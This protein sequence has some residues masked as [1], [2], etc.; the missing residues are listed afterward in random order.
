MMESNTKRALATAFLLVVCGIGIGVWLPK[1]LGIEGTTG[2][3]STPDVPPIVLSP[4]EQHVIATLNSAFSKPPPVDQLLPVAKSIAGGET[5]L[6]VPKMD[7]V[8]EMFYIC[9]TV[10]S[11]ADRCS[12]QFYINNTSHLGTILRSGTTLSLTF[13]SETGEIY[14]NDRIG[15]SI[16]PKE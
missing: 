1:L 4:M 10:V 12:S 14:V 8:V 2:Q 9:G 15:Y 5:A 11:S 13:N 3:K 16:L 6:L 7:R